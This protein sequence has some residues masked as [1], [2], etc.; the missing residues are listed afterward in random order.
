[1]EKSKMHIL[2]T[3]LQSNQKN[4]NFMFS[5]KEI[6]ACSLTKRS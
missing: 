2:L 5:E 6:I 1:M 4:T 3:E